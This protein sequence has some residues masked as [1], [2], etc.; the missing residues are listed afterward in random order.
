LEEDGK[1]L[2]WRK[3]HKKWK[4]R[5]AEF[6][7]VIDAV[8]AERRTQLLSGGKREVTLPEAAAALDRKL[9]LPN[10]DKRR[11]MTVAKFVNGKDFRC[12]A[13]AAAAADERGAGG[14]SSA[15]GSGATEAAP[16]PKR[17][18]GR[19]KHQQPPASGNGGDSSNSDDSPA[20]Q[21]QPQRKRR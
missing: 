4:G 18:R 19:G 9:G 14:S 17:G 16:P 1:D 7:A 8:W 5:W 2:S 21:V 10:H 15:S 13:A 11:G 6:K 20:K 12:N 3:P